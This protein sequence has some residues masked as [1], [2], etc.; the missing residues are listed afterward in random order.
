MFASATPSKAQQPDRRT[1]RRAMRAIMPLAAALILGACDSHKLKNPTMLT[2]PY[3]RTQLW[4]VVPPL[5]ESGVSNV[6]TDRIADALT[7]QAEQVQGLNAVPVNRVIIAMRRLGLASVTSPNEAL[8]LMSAL[9][10]DAL[11]MGTV[12]AYDPYPPMKLG[13][14]VQL[15][16]KEQT[17][18]QSIDPIKLTRAHTELPAPAAMN[19]AQPTAQAAGVF[20]NTNHQTLMWLGEFTSGRKQPESAYGEDVYLVSMDLYTQFVAWR[21]LHDLLAFEQSR[22]TPPDAQASA[23]T[24]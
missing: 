3:E 18:N 23:A 10:V 4:A 5:N 7:E 15:F 13:M 1:A 20:D 24:E 2:A 11:L 19:P 6:R 12:T 9:G 22:L 14:A 8:A 16:T 21:L 17:P